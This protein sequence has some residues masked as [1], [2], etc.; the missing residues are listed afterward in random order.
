VRRGGEGGE[1]GRREKGAEQD[2]IDHGRIGEPLSSP[3]M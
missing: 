1:G 3:S 2:R